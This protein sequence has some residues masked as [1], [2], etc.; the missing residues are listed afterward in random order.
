IPRVNSHHRTEMISASRNRASVRLD[1]EVGASRY[2]IART[3]RRSGAQAVRLE[4]QEENGDFRSLA[5]QVRTAADQVVQILGLGAAA[6]MQAVVLPQGDF[7]RFLKAQPRD[8]RSMLRTL[9]RLDVYERMR[10]RAQRLSVL[11]K[12]TIESL[13][14]LLADEY[15]GLDEAVIVGLEAEHARIAGSLAAL[16]E[17]RDETQTALAHLRGQHAKTRELRQAEERRTAL[18]RQAAEVREF[19]ARLEAAARAVPLLP[20]LEEAARAAIAAQAAVAA[21]VTA[22]AQLESAQKDWKAKAALRNAAAQAAE[23]IP[24]LRERVARLHQVL[25]RLPERAQLQAALHR[26]A[27]SQKALEGERSTLAAAVAAARDLQAQQ[28]EAVQLARQAVEASGHDLELDERLQVVRDRAIELGAA[29]RSAAERRLDRD[30]KRRAAEELSGEVGRL[31][32]SLAAARASAAAAEHDLAAAEEAFHRATRLN[33]ANHLRAG[34]VP[35]EPCPVC[36]Q[37]VATPPPVELAPEVE[38]ARAALLKTRETQREAEA[39]VRQ[40]ESRLTGE[41]ARLLAAQQSLT[42]LEARCTELDS[43][44]A[45]KEAEIRQALGDRA[46][47]EELAVE[48]WIEAQLATLATSRKADLAAKEQLA[49]A[50]RTLEKARSEETAARERLAAR[51][52]ALGQLAEEHGANLER[53]VVLEAEIQ[54]VTESAD[55]AAEASGLEGEIRQLEEGLRAASE[56]EAAAQ[57]QRAAAQEV[58][59][60]T[61]EAAQ[62]QEGEARRRAESR[63]AEIARAGFDGEAAV[64]AALLDE[65]TARRLEEQVRQH[66]QDR[67]AVE[68]RLAILKTE[69]GEERVSDE[70][71]AAAER[72]AADATREVEAALGQE[73]RLAEQIGRM[74]ERLARAAELRV[75]L[76]IEEAS[77]GVYDL[78][79]GDLRSDKFQAYVLHEVFTELVQGASA[80]LLRL[81]GERYSLQFQND[82]I[83]VIDHDN[84]DETRISDT[85]S[86]GETFLT[87]LALALELSD[88]VQRAVGAV[89][90]DSLFIDEGFGTLDP[91]TLALVSETL[92][93]LLVGGR[94]VGIITHI[95]ELR[96]EFAQQVIVTKHQGFS[97]VE[98]RGG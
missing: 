16:R 57:T 19:A 85:L 41:Q 66:A 10:E 28:Q 48:A 51:E 11:K 78:L 45:A 69:L 87:S 14:K 8:R 43:G 80:R 72:L 64:R 90:L 53:L 73:Q 30:Q 49:K 23:A 20:L 40:G 83:R 71:L 25:G 86:G 63:D 93:G 18:E 79:A 65:A 61:A 27:Q 44:V 24:V 96:D 47:G 38:A 2:R 31:Q 92:Q 54:A 5:D 84:A 76:A 67:H 55:P 95:P 56:E 37:L 82:E 89:N 59:R 70:Q 33:E 94:M 97:T 74:R 50:E 75:Q 21:A 98:V 12:G 88:Q 4:E 13:Q 77:F 68:E 26:Q 15:E 3:L 17:R 39:L 46:P 7:A 81:T 1:F 29:R 6:F 36:E 35:G 60:L 22:K 52:A 32:E 62:T 91:D 9:L 34:L 42:E 58:E